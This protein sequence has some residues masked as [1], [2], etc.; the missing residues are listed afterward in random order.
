MATKLDERIDTTLPEGAS[1][2]YLPIDGPDVVA[3]FI[4]GCLD[5]GLLR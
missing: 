3:G 2:K 1:P 4:L 5:Q